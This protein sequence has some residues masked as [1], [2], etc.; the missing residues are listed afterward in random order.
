MELAADLTWRV[1]LDFPHV[2]MRRAATKENVDHGLVRR[3]ISRSRLR[4]Q[5][6][7]QAKTAGAAQGK[8]TDFQEAA[9]REAIAISRAATIDGQHSSTPKSDGAQQQTPSQPTDQPQ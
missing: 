2:L 9:A 4:L 5:N 8:T 1:C 3:S 6:E 7:W